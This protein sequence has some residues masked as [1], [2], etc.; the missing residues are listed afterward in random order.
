METFAFIEALTETLFISTAQA[1]L[2]ILFFK[3]MFNAVPALPSG[4]KYYLWYASLLLIFGL[5]IYSLVTIYDQKAQTVSLPLGSAIAGAANI[6]ISWMLRLKIWEERYAGVISAMYLTGVT[7]QLFSLVF[8]WF[9][10]KSL[11]REKR[12]LNDPLWN[13]RLDILR[14]KLDLVKKVTIHVSD[15]ISVPITAGFI[16]PMIL[17]PVAM[18]NNLSIEQAESVLLHELAHIK[19]H[20]YL[21]NIFQRI[22]E[23]ILF[24]NPFVWLLSKEICREREYC[25]DEMVVDQTADPLT[26]AKALLCLEEQ[27]RHNVFAMAAKGPGKYPLLNRIQR[28]TLM[29]SQNH[30]PQP[31]LIALITIFCVGIS[32]ALALPESKKEIAEKKTVARQISPA[33]DTIVTNTVSDTL[34][35]VSPV[36][37]LNTKPVAVIPEIT[38]VCSV[39]KEK[40]KAELDKTTTEISKLVRESTKFLNS[41][42]WKQQ[43]EQIKMHTAEIQKQFDSPDW[44]Q[45]QKELTFNS[46]EIT[47]M[48]VN[49]PEWKKFQNDILKNGLELSRDPGNKDLKRVQDDLVRNMEE[50][51]K[52]FESPEWKARQEEIQKK[53]EQFSARFNSPEW[54]KKEA[55]LNKKVEEMQ[56]K[57]END[58]AMKQKIKELEKVAEDIQLKMQNLP[59]DR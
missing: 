8:A 55:E 29:K 10:L 45:L 27:K 31:R 16:R 2:I 3:V 13:N 48:I 30:T 36:A 34:V 32:L 25:C 53:A 9:K 56:K 24:F 42:E 26:Y 44:K 11:S 49:N 41:E 50:I 58:P 21:M 14:G 19:R 59:K 17:L 1:F 37:D 22:M 33:E 46:T 51:Q 20:D 28:I 47:A 18:V 6:K 54:K 7:I 43:Q 39:E 4:I 15:K 40:L 52:K 23:S 5:F 38:P 12:L 35:Q 57:F